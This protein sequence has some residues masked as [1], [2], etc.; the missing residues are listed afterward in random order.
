MPTAEF[1][2][3]L[4]FV[5]LALGLI[6]FVALWFVVAPYGRHARGGFGP[7]MNARVGWFI[8]ECPALFGFLGFFLLGANRFAPAPLALASLWCLHYGQRALVYPL[9]MP[10]SAKP[11]PAL[12]VGLAISFNILNASVNAPQIAAYGRYESHWLTDPRFLIGAAVFLIGFLVNL[13]A[14]A[15]LRE[16][17]RTSDGRYRVPSGA[18][19]DLVACPNYLGEIVEWTGW[20]IATWSLAGTAFALYTAANLVPRAAEHLAWYR[21]SFPDYPKSR[22]AL[23]PW[24]Y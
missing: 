6:T 23:V 7:H 13:R 22:R 20:A 15:V 9:R 24:L 8:M 17:K 12:V 3:A 5:E 21:R 10:A 4:V 11:M 2:R 18:L 16:L 19:Y 1:H 14:D